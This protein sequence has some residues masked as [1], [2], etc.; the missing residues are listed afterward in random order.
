VWSTLARW[1]SPAAAGAD[2]ALGYESALPW[3]LGVE[4][5]DRTDSPY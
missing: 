1:W 4:P 3:T 5:A 2:P